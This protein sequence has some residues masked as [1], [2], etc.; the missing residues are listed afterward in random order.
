MATEPSGVDP[1][2]GFASATVLGLLAIVSA[3]SVAALHDALFGEQLAGS[4]V[5]HLRAQA[6]A[7]FGIEDGLLRL[8]AQSVPEDHSY[9][10]RPIPDSGESVEVRLHHTGTGS[11]P[12]GFSG[13]QFALHRLEVESTGF[14]SRGIRAKQVQGIVRVMPTGG[15]T[16]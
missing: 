14:T 2:R 1:Q 15:A 7:D 4:R 6:L 5:L 11:L 3:L 16:P 12:A 10:L 8:A 9:A 13:G